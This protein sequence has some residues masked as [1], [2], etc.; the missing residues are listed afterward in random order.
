MRTGAARQRG[1]HPLS[2]TSRH[3][4][5]RRRRRAA[6]HRQVLGQSL[7]ECSAGRYASTL[8]R[9]R[10]RSAAE[11]VPR[12]PAGG[13]FLASAQGRPSRHRTVPRAA[14]RGSLCTLGG[15]PPRGRTVPRA[16]AMQQLRRSEAASDIIAG[17]HCQPNGWFGLW[18]K[19]HILRG[20]P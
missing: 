6:A 8:W 13:I 17:R 9:A 7:T 14:G 16:V 2:V 18:T 12:G 19:H 4:Q 5:L 11:S 10:S 3:G 20:T 15:A 1:L